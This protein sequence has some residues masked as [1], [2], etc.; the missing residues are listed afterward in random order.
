[1]NDNKLLAKALLDIAK[2][3]TT[4]FVGED[5][6]LIDAANKIGIT[7]PS[8]D[9]AVIKTVYAEIDK[10]NLNGVVLPKEA[11]EKGLPTLI[12]KQIN[13]EH[14]G[15]GRICGYIINA[16]INKDLIEI[17]AV[18]FKSLF[19]EEMEEVKQKFDEKKLC[20]SFE[21]WNK[22][23]ETGDSVV[24]ELSDGTRSI[25]PIIFHGCGLLLANPPA[26]PKA[27]VYK[28]VAKVLTEAEKIVDKVFGEDLIFASLAIEE[29]ACK[30]CDTCT[31][32]KEET[33]VELYE[34]L[35]GE[36]TLE[37]TEEEIALIE[38]DYDE[39]LQEVEEAKKLKDEERQKL[40]DDDFA[41]VVTVKNKV[42]G[43]PRKIRMFPIQDEAH[44]RNALAR[45]PQAEET[46]KKLGISKEEV[47]KKILKKAKELNMTELLKKYEKSSEETQVVVPPVE[48]KIDAIVA[49]IVETKPEEIKA[50]ETK[51]EVKAHEEVKLIK[52]ITEET[53]STIEIPNETGNSVERKGNRKCTRVYSDG[54]EEVSTE[55]FTVVDT[56]S[57]AQLEEKVNTAKAEK[58]TEITTLKVEHEKILAEKDTELKNLKQELEQKTQE[59]IKAK[60]EDNG[61][62]D[63][64][65]STVDVT[66]DAEKEEIRKKR[67]DFDRKTFGRLPEDK[68]D[69]K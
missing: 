60:V 6:E 48:T 31:C 26:C 8:P 58:D 57:H 1:M 11:V 14:N 49:P 20:V 69:K 5:K 51:E 42:T 29:S 3:S 46:L 53:V 21:I 65:F 39:T 4:T 30:K 22:N 18:L 7:L 52:I 10:P 64:T 62:P 50:E 9:L 47:L 12:G 27:K 28:L 16:Q 67:K 40:S 66:K 17:T 23:P 45:L 63:L 2:N 34:L 36:V 61:Q 41:V 13:W 15:A 43:E 37:I 54:K 56:Y 19:P 55:E 68:K 38:K 59:I 32:E 35:V 25:D 44:V 24:K 33:K